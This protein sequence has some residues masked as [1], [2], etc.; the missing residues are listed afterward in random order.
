MGAEQR[1]YRSSGVTGVSR[2]TRSQRFGNP[3]PTHSERR[4]ANRAIEDDT[5]VT[6]E[7]LNFLN[8]RTPELPE[9][10]NS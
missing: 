7:L 2:P 9:L 6:T 8:S 4:T 1:S 5:I 10:P 3:K